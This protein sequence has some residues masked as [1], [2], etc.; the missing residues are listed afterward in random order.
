MKRALEY[1]R[2][3]LA[4]CASAALVGTLVLPSISAAETTPALVLEQGVACKDFA[5]GLSSRGGNQVYREFFDR[6][7]PK[8]SYAGS[9]PGRAVS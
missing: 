1:A 6:N 5:L 9:A 3:R 7:G 8:T 4:F 2:S